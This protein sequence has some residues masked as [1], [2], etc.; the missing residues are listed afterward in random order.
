MTGGIN[1]KWAYRHVL[2][3]AMGLLVVF[4]VPDTALAQ[5][6]IAARLQANGITPDAQRLVQFAAQGD[7]AM[8]NLLFDAGV[9]ANAVEPKR[10]VTALHNAAAQGHKRIVLRLLELGANVNAA[11]WHGV[12]PLLT[13]VHGGHFEI[14]Q[15]LLQ[16]GADPNQRPKAATTALI[17]AVWQGNEQLLDLLLQAGANPALPDVF[18]VSPLNAAQLAGRAKLA[19]RIDAELAGK[20]P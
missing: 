12:T 4:G 9:K 7:W 1:W 6:G 16:A 18:D 5:D 11:D 8:L 17:A 13:A 10:Q 2:V 20:K 15:I 3:P 14:V 19:A